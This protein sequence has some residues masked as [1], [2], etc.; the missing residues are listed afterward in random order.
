MRDLNDY[1]QTIAFEA[2]GDQ[3]VLDEDRIV[4]IGD[5]VGPYT[6]NQRSGG[7]VAFN[8]TNHDVVNALGLETPIYVDPVAMNVFDYAFG[9]DSPLFTSLVIPEQDLGNQDG[10]F[11]II[12]GDFTKKLAFGELLDFTDYEVDGIDFFTI[13]GIDPGA[14]VSTDDAFIVGLTRAGPCSVKT[15]ITGRRVFEGDDGP[16]DPNVIPLPGSVWLLPGGVAGLFG[17]HRRRAA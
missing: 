12:F 1:G 15:T 8:S 17:L 10:M 4:G 7:F 16:T 13:A 5:S 3:F 6:L 11:D 2:F 14:N 9:D